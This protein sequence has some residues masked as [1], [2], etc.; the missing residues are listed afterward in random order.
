MQSQVSVNN[1]TN[2]EKEKELT[3]KTLSSVFV[4]SNVFVLPPDIHSRADTHQVKCNNC[5]Q[6]LLNTE[7]DDHLLAH[8]FEENEVREQMNRE[9]AQQR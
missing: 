2:E 8:E 5:N 3:D 9:L 7:M 1:K 6:T 4:Q